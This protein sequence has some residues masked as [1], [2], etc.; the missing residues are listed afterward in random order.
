MYIYI[1]TYMYI[2]IYMYIYIYI[3]IYIYV[4]LY[5]HIRC[6]PLLVDPGNGETFA[7]SLLWP[8]K[9]ILEGD[10]IT[11]DYLPNVHINDPTRK[12]RLLAFNPHFNPHNTD[13]INEDKN[14]NQTVNENIA[15][16][17][18]NTYPT[19]EPRE[20][21]ITQKNLD[22]IVRDKKILKVFCDRT[23]HLNPSL[24]ISSGLICKC[25]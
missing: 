7:I 25:I 17:K 15:V 3:F 18:L 2:C 5:I 1:Y 24:M 20:W 16:N 23:D 13:D 4:Y 11:R 10:L 8:I 22:N 12:L 14:I 9:D 21:D 19:L 6:C